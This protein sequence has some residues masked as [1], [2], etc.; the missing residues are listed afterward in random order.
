MGKTDQS[1]KRK[2]KNINLYTTVGNQ[3]RGDDSGYS[4]PYFKKKIKPLKV[5]KQVSWQ[6][7]CVRACVCVYAVFRTKSLLNHLIEYQTLC[8][9]ILRKLTL[10]N[11]SLLSV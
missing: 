10:E 9:L 6:I 5:L 11:L 4:G 1:V 7:M 3:V 8:H 2:G